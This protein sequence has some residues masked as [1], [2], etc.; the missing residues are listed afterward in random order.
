[1]AYRWHKSCTSKERDGSSNLEYAL[2]TNPPVGR[3]PVSCTRR[4]DDSIISIATAMFIQL[5]AHLL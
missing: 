2:S 3:E 1:M 5:H 4:D